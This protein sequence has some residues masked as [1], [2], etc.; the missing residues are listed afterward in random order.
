MRIAGSIRRLAA[1][2]TRHVHQRPAKLQEVAKHRVLILRRGDRCPLSPKERRESRHCRTAAQGQK[3][4]SRGANKL[5]DGDFGLKRE[6]AQLRNPLAAPLRLSNST[7]R[8]VASALT[9]SMATT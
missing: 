5:G 9:P 1:A 7:E 2:A 4:P 3:R 6:K 8:Q